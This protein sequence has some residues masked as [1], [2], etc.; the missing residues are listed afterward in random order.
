MIILANNDYMYN[1]DYAIFSEVYNIIY[2]VVSIALIAFCI[3]EKH[4]LKKS[5][6]TELGV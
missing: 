4:A 2:Y 3:I 6:A 1:E 5:A